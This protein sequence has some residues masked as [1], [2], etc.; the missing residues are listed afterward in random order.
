MINAE[1]YKDVWGLVQPQPGT[2][3]DN[4]VRFTTERILYLDRKGFENG[5]KEEISKLFESI[6]KCEKEPGLL[7]RFPGCTR[8]DSFDNYI[9]AMTASRIC[10]GGKLAG[11]IWK[12]GVQKAGWYLNGEDWG[13][14][15]RSPFLWRN[16]FFIAYSHFC[17]HDEVNV[18]TKPILQLKIN[19]NAKSEDQDGKILSWFMVRELGNR[20][21]SQYWSEML[22]KQYEF[23]IGSVLGRYFDYAGFQHPNAQALLYVFN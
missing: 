16:P 10:D 6:L 14:F 5:A 8:Q 23:G 1:E 4:G 2:T 9:A 20:I 21:E 7:E 12:R 13:W 19:L 11:R 22:R 17:A 15:V 3:S 18:V